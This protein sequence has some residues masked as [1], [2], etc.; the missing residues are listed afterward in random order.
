M[1]TA[2]QVIERLEAAAE[3]LRRLPDPARGPFA[4]RS[5]WPEVLRPTI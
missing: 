5:N 3:T 4:L 2:D 1:W